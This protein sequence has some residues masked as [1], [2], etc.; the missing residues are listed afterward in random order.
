MADTVIFPS[1]KDSVFRSKLIDSLL[2]IRLTLS[3]KK[4]TSD[5]IKKND[6]KKIVDN[7]KERLDLRVRNAIDDVFSEYFVN[8]DIKKNNKSL[9][10]DEM[11]T[12]NDSSDSIDSFNSIKGPS[13]VKTDSHY[14]SSNTSSSDKAA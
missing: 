10:L 2:D 5:F 14:K 6:L 7:V 4:V 13:L 1:K 3:I 11:Q 12:F 8:K 9:S